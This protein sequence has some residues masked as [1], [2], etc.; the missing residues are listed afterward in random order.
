MR[1]PPV[2][3]D[4]VVTGRSKVWIPERA[5]DGAATAD[6]PDDDD[7][8]EA[9]RRTTWKLARYELGELHRLLRW[10]HEPLDEKPPENTVP[11]TLLELETNTKRPAPNPQD[12]ET[13][14][15][16]F[17]PRAER[18][19]KSSSDRASPDNVDGRR[20][21]SNWSR[22]RER[23][24]ADKVQKAKRPRRKASIDLQDLPPISFKYV[25]EALRKGYDLSPIFDDGAPRVSV[26][27]PSIGRAPPR[28]AQ[29]L[30]V[31]GVDASAMIMP[32]KSISA[33][34]ELR[35]RREPEKVAAYSGK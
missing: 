6:S 4:D 26:G 12:Y 3:E 5:E 34:F 13:I 31:S 15:R 11:K 8:T 32:V 19:R 20:R 17:Q 16:S 24:Y 35:D 18:A 21:L 22:K 14:R 7:G 23:S 1:D 25:D 9:Y 33:E 28:R 30:P 27:R 10:D 29:L 2:T